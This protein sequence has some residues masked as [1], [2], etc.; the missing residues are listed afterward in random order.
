MRSM[1]LVGM[2][3]VGCAGPIPLEKYCSELTRANCERSQRCG[4][5]TREIDC[6]TFSEGDNCLVFYL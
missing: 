6:S 1:G 4:T 3:L 2:V 5:M